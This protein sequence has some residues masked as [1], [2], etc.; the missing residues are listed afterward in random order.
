MFDDII[1]A[2]VYSGSCEATD[3]ISLSVAVDGDIY[4]PNVFTPNND[5]INDH[6]TVFTDERVRRVVY[7]EIFDR[8]GNQVFVGSDFPPNDP[9]LGWDGTFKDKP[10]NPAVFA[11]IAKVELINGVQVSKKGDITLL[12]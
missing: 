4:V 11:Y 3:Q 9:L 5:Y 7:L 12:R 2:T 8:W 10:M 1:S 6:V